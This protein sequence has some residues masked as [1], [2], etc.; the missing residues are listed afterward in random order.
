MKLLINNIRI[1]VIVVIVL[2]TALLCYYFAPVSVFQ[3]TN[4]TLNDTTKVP[5]TPTVPLL[6][7]ADF[8]IQEV[9]TSVVKFINSTPVTYEDLQLFPELEKYMRGTNDDVTVWR[10]GWR[11]IADF[12]GNGSQYDT[13]VKKICKDKDIVECNRGTLIEYRNHSYK[14]F[15]H[16]YGELKRNPNW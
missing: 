10:Q 9:N 13:L 12:E 8:E 3:S 14:I 7:D 2:I 5:D 1:T 15:M 16:E 4:Q 6:I 11:L